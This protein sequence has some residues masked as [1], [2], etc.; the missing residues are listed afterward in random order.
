MIFKHS[1]HLIDALSPHM[2]TPSYLSTFSLVS[3]L[4]LGV[5][6]S[7]LHR[8]TLQDPGISI[9]T[10]EWLEL[11]LSGHISYFDSSMTYRYLINMLAISIY[12]YLSSRRYR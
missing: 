12:I 6:H 7:W 9:I 5:S 1:S 4:T 10:V 2:I 11:T 8:V 3:N